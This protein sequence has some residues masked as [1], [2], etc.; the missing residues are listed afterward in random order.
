LQ[1]ATGSGLIEFG[2]IRQRVQERMK[3]Y[4]MLGTNKNEE[5]EK[6]SQH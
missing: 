1:A 3:E 5:E 2:E 4:N 6:K